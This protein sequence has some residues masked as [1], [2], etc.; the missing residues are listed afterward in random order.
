M[1]TD[2]RKEIILEIIREKKTVSVAELRDQL[3]VSESTI[4]RDMA[5]LAA[6][7]DIRRIF[8][9]AV[10]LPEDASAE[11]IAEEPTDDEKKQGMIRIART[12]AELIRPGDRVYI[13]SGHT[14]RMVIAYLTEK[15]AEYVTNSLPAAAKLGAAGFKTTLIGGSMNGTG[16][17]TVGADAIL[18]VQK[19]RFSIGFFGAD[20]VSVSMGFTT[21][22]VREGLV[23]RTAAAAT[24]SA[25]RF[26]LITKEKFGVSRTVTF[27]TLG[28]GII[29]T[30]AEPPEEIAR[31]QEVRVVKLGLS[32]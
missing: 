1:L 28:S 20:G 14:V 9:G 23:R 5:E 24:V 15:D 17:V 2:E 4:R 21:A 29:L 27:A 12:A 26:F 8:G 7:G 18:G 13:D 31:V 19:N 6:R 11:E 3:Q 32:E 25:R 22:G 16:S 10:F 30:D